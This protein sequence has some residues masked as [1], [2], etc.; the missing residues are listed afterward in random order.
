VCPLNANG[1][2]NPDG[3]QTLQLADGS[4]NRFVIG[5]DEGLY[6]VYLKLPNGFTCNHCTFQWTYTT[7]NSWGW[8]DED[9]TFGQ[10][11]CGDQEMFRGCAD[12]QIV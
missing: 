8:C 7:A 2:E 6:R 9:K 12:I 3:C 4:G 11:G 1:S 5:S 10:L